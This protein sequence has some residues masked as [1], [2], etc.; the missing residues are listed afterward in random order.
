MNAML[1]D[2]GMIGLGTMGRNLVL[3][4]A[5]KGFD[6]A[7]FNRTSSVTD[8]F[9]SGLRP[10]QRVQPC[11]SLDELLGSLKR[12]R[13][14]M[15]MVDAGRP[16]DAVLEGLDPLLEPD[17]IVVD[18]GNSHFRDTD[19]R[20]AILDGRKVRYLGVGISG[21][22]L[23]ARHGPSMMPG[24]PHAAF[25]AVQP[26]FEAVAAKVE[27]R[28]CVS[29]LGPGSAGHYVK[30]VHNGIEYGFMQ[31]IAESYAL[32]KQGLGLTNQELA[33]VYGEWQ[34]AE[35]ESYLVE[36]TSQILR[37]RDEQ[38][39]GSLIDVIRGE[40]G[41]LGTGMWT[42]QSAMDLH[43]PTPTIDA[44]VSMR[45]LS[46]LEQ[47]RAEARRIAGAGGVTGGTTRESTPPALTVKLVRD[48]LY[49]GLIV[50]YTQGFAQLR[51]ASEV[52]GY[53]LSL[54]EVASI[55][56]GGCIIRSALLK[57]I[58]AVF[59]RQPGLASLLLDPGLS[60]EVNVRRG[61]L[62]AVVHAGAAEQIP[63]PGMMTVLAYVDSYQTDWL[64]TNLIQAQRDFFG[65]HTYR[66]V[67]QEGVFHTDWSS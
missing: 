43:V 67:D 53:G 48:A 4:M 35:L 49:A 56:R 19:R 13:V 57:A 20:G 10:D 41:Q 40:A 25:E 47:E 12:P 5:D 51:R 65:A 46:G 21:G 16:V 26:I 31:L 42:S 54:G 9:V 52:Q 66:R 29:Y 63:I 61:A 8:T 2:I 39:G 58:S 7:V 32:L 44:A 14:I 38:S 22:E 60:G 50:A 27:G 30:M 45:S 15:M 6:V 1:N 34:E 24:G 17:D 33:D 23:G 55:W 62:A 37:R 11:D 36:I 64:P 59:E 18:G 3:N 28:A